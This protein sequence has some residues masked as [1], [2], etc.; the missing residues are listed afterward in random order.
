MKIEF[1]KNVKVALTQTS[2][3]LNNTSDEL[4]AAVFVLQSDMNKAKDELDEDY[5]DII[6]N[7][8]D[9]L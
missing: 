2:D 7:I 6:K 4:E 1:V 9:G 5:A 8:N 3:Y